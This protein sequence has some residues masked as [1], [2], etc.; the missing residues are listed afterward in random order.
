MLKPLPLCLIKMYISD[1][2]LHL[3]LQEAMLQIAWK[4]LIS[5]QLSD[6][7]NIRFT[8]RLPVAALKLHSNK[9]IFQFLIHIRFLD[10]SICFVVFLRFKSAN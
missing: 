7:E 2:S 5:F 6:I 4:F 10:N 8:K 3:I 9:Q 1:V